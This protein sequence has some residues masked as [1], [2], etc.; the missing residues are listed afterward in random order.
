MTDASTT[1]SA[2]APSTVNALEELR[3]RA[4]AHLARER[5]R[6]DKR[7]AAIQ[8]DAREAARA[9]EYQRWGELLKAHF[10]RLSKRMAEISLPNYFS[11]AME[12]VLIPL[13][14]ASSPQE[15]IER[16]FTKAR[17]L[18]RAKPMIAHR[19][20]QTETERAANDEKCRLATTISVVSEL[21][22][23]LPAPR[24]AMHAPE[25]SDEDKRL[26][27][28]TSSDGFEI[29]LGRTAKDN[30]YLTVRVARGSDLWLHLRNRPG[31][32]AV[33]KVPRG[34]E[35]PRTTLIEA[36]QL[37]AHFS[38]VP[39]GEIEEVTY[40]FRK[41]VSKP[42]GAKPGLVMVAAGKTIAVRHDERAMKE[43][44]K[45]HRA[46]ALHNAGSC[47][48]TAHALYFVT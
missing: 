31:C 15:N 34:S 46:A 40:T 30:D 21:E 33:V 24:V 35:T 28:F 39:N 36:A 18:E 7:L 32:H 11:D 12:H 47:E 37:C 10:P 16:Y 14:P 44:T 26:R 3:R 19:L 42:K 20:H 4:L 1:R 9:A 48:N 25:K 22:R 29:L 17:K 13:D 8:A 6:L 45:A 38:H 41:H 27:R 5:K 2:A 23:L 43:W